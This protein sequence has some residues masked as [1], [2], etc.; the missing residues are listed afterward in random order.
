MIGD[1]T[2]FTAELTQLETT[3]STL[4]QYQD[5]NQSQEVAEMLRTTHK[6]MLDAHKRAKKFSNRERLMDL[7]ETDYS[8]LQQLSKEYEPYYSLWTTADDWFRNHQLWLTQ[9][10]T[11]LDAPDMEEKV[12]T[13][14]KTTNKVIRFFREKD[15]P[16]ILKICESIKVELDKYKPFLP[17]AIALRKDGM[18]T[19]HWEQLTAAVGFEVSPTEDFT[20]QSVID[21]NL[22]EHVGV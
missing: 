20:F 22:V 14:I 11:E 13:Y 19:R 18:K 8:Y 15:L 17:L 21:L 6:K 1:Q 9:P 10:W 12:S 7:N 16:V 2:N 3:I 4:S 5:I